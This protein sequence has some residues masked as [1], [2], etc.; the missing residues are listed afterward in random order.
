MHAPCRR[1]IQPWHY[2]VK[3]CNRGLETHD[4]YFSNSVTFADVRTVICFKVEQHKTSHCLQ[5][6]STTD[7]L[8]LQYDSTTHMLVCSTIAQ[9]IYW[10]SVRQHN[11]H[12][13]IQCN[14]TTHTRVWRTVADANIKMVGS[15]KNLDDI[16]KVWHLFKTQKSNIFFRSKPSAP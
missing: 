15:G 16:G 13:V 2:A 8:V 9:Q 14:S 10:S 7:F 6:E 4:Y 5:Y 11:A 12:L 3:W 1:C